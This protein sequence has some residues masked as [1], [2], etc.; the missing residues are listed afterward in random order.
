MAT[1]YQRHSV[2]STEMVWK[3]KY[4][5]YTHHHTHSHTH[6]QTSRTVPGEVVCDTCSISISDLL[7]CQAECGKVLAPRMRIVVYRNNR[8]VV[9]VVVVEVVV[10]V[11]IIL[12]AV[13]VVAVIVVVVVVIVARAETVIALPTTN[14]VVCVTIKSEIYSS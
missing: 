10:V 5:L 7:P 14:F 8:V 12:I 3:K 11:V 1:K 6:T 2:K 4:I 13:V 9:V